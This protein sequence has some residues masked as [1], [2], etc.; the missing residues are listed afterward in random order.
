MFYEM[1]ERARERWYVSP[2]CTVRDT[3]EY[4]MQQGNLRDAQI[5]A[6]KTYLFLKIGCR[7]KPLSTL[8]SSGKFNTL[9]LD[10][11]EI[12]NKVRE[13]FFKNP[14]AAALYEYACLKNSADEQLAAKLAQQIRTDVDGIQ[15]KQFFQKAFYGV[16]YTDYLFSLPMGA[17]KTYLM[18]AFIWICILPVMSQIIQ[19]LHT[20]LSSWH[21]LD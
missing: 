17:G 4:M 7:N 20:I 12:S 9:N 11:L 2:D 21:L 14:A 1:I 18:A 15:Y 16:S 8:F 5:D 19:R 13:Y 3:I 10:D 6:I